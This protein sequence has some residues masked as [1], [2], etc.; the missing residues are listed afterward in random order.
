MG[1]AWAACADVGERYAGTLS[2]AMNMIGALAGACGAAMAGYLF[3]QGH[4]EMVFMIFA[5]V[6]ALAALCWLGVDVTKRL[7]GGPKDRG[8]ALGDEL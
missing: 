5:G 7:A 3:R 1:P 2:G 6:Y 8:T 4:A